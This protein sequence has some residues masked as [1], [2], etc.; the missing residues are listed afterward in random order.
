MKFSIRQARTYSGLTQKDMA[1]ALGIDRSTYI[2]IEKDA[3][4]ATV[5]QIND[6]ANVTK[7]PVEDLFLR[8][9]ST[10]VESAE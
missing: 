4:R 8:S 9:D 7:I 6:I 3:S 2:K 10:K 1:D 5:K